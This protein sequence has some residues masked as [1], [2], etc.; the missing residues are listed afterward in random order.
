MKDLRAYFDAR[1]EDMVAEL[2]RLVEIE[3][4]SRDKMAVDALGA[5]IAERARALGAT[6][7]LDR[8]AE[9]GDHVIA[10]WGESATRKQALI[11]CHMDTIWSLGTLAERPVRIEDGRFYGPGSHDMKAGIA[12]TLAAMQALRAWG[13]Q[14]QRPVTALFTSDEELGSQ[15]SRT[16]IESQARRSDLALVLEPSLDDGSLKTSRKGTG[17]FVVTTTGVAAHAGGAHDEGINAIEELA[18]QI[19][20]I[21]GM[22]DY[23]RGTTVNV[24]RVQGGQ[25]T[26]VVP[27]QA[28]AWVDLRVTTPQEG[29]RMLERLSSLKAKLPGASVRVQ[30]ELSRPPMPRD[31]LMAQTFQR[32]TAIATEVGLALTEGGTGG[33]S[34]GNLVAAL[35]IPTLDGLG[36]VG[37]GAHAL[38]EHVIIRSLPERAAL[39]A[40]LLMRW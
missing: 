36:P 17:G 32:A 28:R 13:W 4:P 14:S 26:N 10:R 31:D 24:G 22:T 16:L 21:Q 20:E 40:A 9:R 15:T 34:D 27:D 1:S 39:L 18:H 11:L 33:A 6:V 37:G 19:L 7:T 25:R 35:G 38:H 2:R 30:G 23:A 5:A 3:S 29:Q 8:Q 12:V